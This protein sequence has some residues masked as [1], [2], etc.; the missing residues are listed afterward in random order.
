MTPSIG[1]VPTGAAI[2]IILSSPF[3]FIVSVAILARLRCR[4]CGARVASVSITHGPPPLPP[5]HR[6]WSGEKVCRP[7]WEELK[8]LGFRSEGK[9]LFGAAEYLESTP[10]FL[11]FLVAIAAAAIVIAFAVFIF[12]S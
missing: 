9:R 12:A 6:L 7:C 10:A 1:N 5:Q 4:R 11:A 8:E 3:L 2:L